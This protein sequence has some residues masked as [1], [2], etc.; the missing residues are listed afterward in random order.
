M[1]PLN[2]PSISPYKVLSITKALAL[3]GMEANLATTASLL[4]T[5]HSDLTKTNQLLQQLVDK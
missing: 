2:E 5:V 4:A 1:D 3:N